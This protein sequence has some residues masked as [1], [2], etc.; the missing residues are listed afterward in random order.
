[1]PRITFDAI[2]VS[3]DAIADPAERRYF[4]ELPTSFVLP[5]EAVD[6]LRAQAG[7][8]LRESAAFRKLQQQIRDVNAAAME[9]AAARPQP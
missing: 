7:K 3:F 6:R 4:M 2:D 9:R 1:M 5:D 8:L